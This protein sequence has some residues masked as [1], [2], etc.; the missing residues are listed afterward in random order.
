MSQPI[1][2]TLAQRAPRLTRTLTLGIIV[3]LLALRLLG[4]VYFAFPSQIA[5]AH[6]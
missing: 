3:L 1:T 6:L 4:V 2:L 5:S